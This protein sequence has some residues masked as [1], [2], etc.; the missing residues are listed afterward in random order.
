ML[1]LDMAQLHRARVDAGQAMLTLRLLAIL[2]TTASGYIIADAIDL[3]PD[4][5]LNMMSRRQW[6]RI[7]G[8]A[9][10]DL[11]QLLL[12]QLLRGWC[13]FIM[14]GLLLCASACLMMVTAPIT[15]LHNDLGV[16][17][18]RWAAVLLLLVRFYPLNLPEQSA[19]SSL[20]AHWRR[21]QEPIHNGPVK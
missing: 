1:L 10:N 9:T 15:D 16:F 17:F 14:I 4:L 5:L 7:E 8:I 21:G 3:I 18:C 6:L 20:S 12:G 13:F 11:L 19:L 2:T